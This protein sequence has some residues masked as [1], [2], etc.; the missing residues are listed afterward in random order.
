MNWLNVVIIFCLCLVSVSARSSEYYEM[1]EDIEAHINYY[2]LLGVTEDSPTD[3]IRRKFRKL[4]LQYHPDKSV[5]PQATEKY[6]K[7]NFAYKILS[8]P[9]TKKEYIK[10]L[11]EGVPWDAVYGQY[12]HKYGAPAHDPRW[13]IG[14]FLAFI[15]VCQYSYG[16]YR[17]YIFREM[18]Y[19]TPRYQQ[20]LNELKR[21]KKEQKK[22]NK[23]NPDN[24]NEPEVEMP[25]VEIVGAEKPLV[26]DLLIVHMVL[27]PWTFS[28]WLY[29]Y[30]K[31]IVLYDIL[32]HEKPD[33]D[34]IARKKAGLSKE[35]WEKQKRKLLEKL[36]KERTSAKAKRARR[37][38]KN[39]TPEFYEG[40]D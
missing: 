7:I 24:S 30:I 35:E 15:T 23:N 28:C 17:Y 14:L 25:E 12:A 32:K 4:A 20:A 8:T 18:I 36:E 11:R 6:A 26:K 33:E 38:L 22:K 2:Q 34:E 40:D 37:F 16:W 9:E 39:R 1:V 3:E 19:Q 21:K 29:E 31:W 5:D 27:F 10:L 13:V